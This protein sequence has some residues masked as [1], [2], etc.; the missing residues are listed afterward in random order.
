MS[1]EG[2]TTFENQCSILS[3]LW[4]GYR[5]E[6]QF[7]DFISYNDMGLPLAFFVDEELVKPTEMAKNLIQETFTLLLAGL[8]LED[9]GFESL[10]DL[11]ALG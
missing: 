3:D 8:K 2:G 11:L 1:N 7:E 10:E 4:M 5:H 6:K 9:E